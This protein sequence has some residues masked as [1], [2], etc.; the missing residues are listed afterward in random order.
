MSSVVFNSFKQRFLEGEVPKDDTWTF[1]PVNKTFNNTFVRTQDEFKL[2]QFRSLD[3]FFDHNYDAMN[4]SYFEGI[5]TD[6]DWYKPEDTSGTSKPMFITSGVFDKDGNQLSASNWEDFQKTDFY[7][8]VSGNKDIESYLASGGFYYL[9][10]KDEIRWFADRVN[11]GNN[12]IIG[13]FGD[14]VD[15]VIRGQIGKSE[16][17]PFQGVLDGN[18]HAL[19]DV[20]V[21]CDGDDNGMVGILGSEGTVKNFK[22]VNGPDFLNDPDRVSLKCEK[23]IDIN[24]IKKDGRDINAGILVGRNY[25]RVININAHELGQFRFS[26]FVPQV[27]SVTNKSDSY[28]DFSTVRSKF[29]EGE[30]MYFLNSWCINSPGNCCPYVGYFA[31]GLFAQSARGYVNVTHDDGT[32]ARRIECIESYPTLKSKYNAGICDATLD[33]SKGMT[34]FG[35]FVKAA[36][37]KGIYTGSNSGCLTNPLYNQYA[38][39]E[40]GTNCVLF[41]GYDTKDEMGK[42]VRYYLEINGTAYDKKA[43]K[44][45]RRY[46]FH[47]GHFNYKK[48]LQYKVSGSNFEGWNWDD[49]SKDEKLS[50]KHYYPLGWNDNYAIKCVAAFSNGDDEAADE[51]IGDDDFEIN[52]SDI[53]IY[54]AD[55]IPAKIVSIDW[56]ALKWTPL[57]KDTSSSVWNTINYSL[58][59]KKG[60][61]HYSGTVKDNTD[62]SSGERTRTW[63]YFFCCEEDNP[64]VVEKKDGADEQVLGLCSSLQ[65]ADYKYD[66]EK[67]DEIGWTGAGNNKGRWIY[68]DGELT[69][70]EAYAKF[71]AGDLGI[72]VPDLM[73]EILCNAASIE[74]A[75]DACSESS[76]MFH[77]EYDKNTSGPNHYST[78]ILVDDSDKSDLEKYLTKRTDTWKNNFHF[79]GLHK[80]D[81]LVNSNIYAKGTIVM[82]LLQVGDFQYRPFVHASETDSLQYVTGGPVYKD[83]SA[84]QMWENNTSMFPGAKLGNVSA[85]PGQT[86]QSTLDYFTKAAKLYIQ[87]PNYYG[88]DV[89][90]LWTTNCVRP[91]PENDPWSRQHTP[92]ESWISTL[93]FN[94]NIMR[95]MFDTENDHYKRMAEYDQVNDPEPY[96]YDTHI[97]MSGEYGR[98]L[99]EVFKGLDFADDKYKLSDIPHAILNKP[100]RMN[101]MARAAYYISPIV[102]ANYGRIQ[103]VV[104][105]SERM[106]KGNFVGFIGSIAGKQE[107]GLVDFCSVY[108]KDKFNYFE[109]YPEKPNYD[110][111]DTTA[112]EAAMAKYDDACKN[113]N[114]QVRYKA[115]PIMPGAVSEAVQTLTENPDFDWT[116]YE[117][118]PK[119]SDTKI[120]ED[121]Y[122]AVSSVPTA[123]KAYFDELGIIKYIETNSDTAWVEAG[124]K[125]YTENPD[126]IYDKAFFDAS[127]PIRAFT[128]AWYD[129]YNVTAENVMD[130]V[131]TYKLRPIFNA[132]GLFGKVVPS[133]NMNTLDVTGMVPVSGT[134]F[135]NCNVHYILDDAVPESAV[136]TEELLQKH[137]KDIH[138]TF[139][140]IA[141]MLE[142]QTSETCQWDKDINNSILLNEIN[143]SAE[144]NAKEPVLA[145]GFMS[146]QPNELPSVVATEGSPRQ[147]AG[148][149]AGE[150]TET[151]YAIDL[152]VVINNSVAN[153]RRTLSYAPINQSSA[154][155]F[156]LKRGDLPEG[157]FNNGTMSGSASLPYLQQVAEHVF[158][159]NGN[160]NINNTSLTYCNPSALTIYWGKRGPLSVD[161]TFGSNT[162][163]IPAMPITTGNGEQV[164]TLTAAKEQ[165]ENPV[166]TRTYYV[167]HTEISANNTYH[168][169]TN[170]TPINIDCLQNTEIFK[171]QKVLDIYFDYTYSSKSAF[172]DDWS[173]KQNVSFTS[174]LDVEKFNKGIK[175]ND[176]NIKLGYVFRDELNYSGNGF[177]YNN[178]YLHLGNSVSPKHIRTQLAPNG[179]HLYTSGAAAY[180][181]ND[182][183]ELV[184]ANDDHS[185]GGFLVLD[186]QDRTVMFIDNT[187]GAKIEDGGSYNLQCS[188]VVYNGTSGGLLLEVK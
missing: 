173:F 58:R 70:E 143:V 85:I 157:T 86:F 176:T 56:S 19:E 14:G 13:V 118:Y 96:R 107:R 31:E 89:D 67:P 8:D 172:V 136:N 88:M 24:H 180:Y 82:T 121:D 72:A 113:Y 114:Y 65:F 16:D 69:K 35:F 177:W 10:K 105:S 12:R 123:A 158:K 26:G 81:M 23:Q 87:N 135:Q 132:G 125:V 25:G 61:Y 109:D 7:K 64:R 5:R 6:Y 77:W 60:H 39:T 110:T 22:I 30:N 115:T 104:V 165:L 73:K 46:Y 167:G 146:Y 59:I 90:G 92:R 11:S 119:G 83:A 94:W 161:S 78:R 62:T 163:F 188:P 29:D 162:V 15:G 93:N 66:A 106:N 47:A 124:F 3:D 181:Y 68:Y 38:D 55:G 17:Y 1:L 154:A 152:P 137:S 71:C 79:N 54:T 4:N 145:F 102:G 95:H 28:N 140:A 122:S 98:M 127:A 2:E 108:A 99:P 32:T 174:A 97:V 91:D 120:E 49:E 128:S 160:V 103:H 21:V 76:Y 131:V 184:S 139:G 133:Y 45:Q 134:T 175:P 100:L 150:Y 84:A 116:D 142:V 20:T 36:S 111:M 148:T 168:L 9:L 51:G 80:Y 37:D 41:M 75:E 171:K 52:D 34:R 183:G 129:D 44:G 53:R 43:K 18:G 170:F 179:A 156:N 40:W 63:L 178:N 42:D 141:G 117:F 48:D 151:T 147:K 130:D 149:H 74:V 169:I 155:F 159:T 112:F 126:Y 33:L 144:C 166:N 138:D 164:T 186:S 182:E 27:Y 153:S 187:S 57:N 50:K 185:F 101:N